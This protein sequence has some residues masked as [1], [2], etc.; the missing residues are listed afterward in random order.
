[1]ASQSLCL[2]SQ[3]ETETT[4]LE[5][6]PTPWS[7]LP[8]QRTVQVGHLSRVDSGVLTKQIKQGRQ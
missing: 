6:P 2:P 7:L 1:M 4:L 8:L 5:F 3:Q